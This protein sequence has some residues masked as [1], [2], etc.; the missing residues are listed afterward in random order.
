MR[1]GIVLSLIS[2]RMSAPLLLSSHCRA[3]EFSHVCPSHVF[4]VNFFIIV[5]WSRK[6]ELYLYPFVCLQGIMLH[7]TIFR[8]GRVYQYTVCWRKLRVYPPYSKRSRMCGKYHCIPST[9]A[10]EGRYLETHICRIQ[11]RS[12]DCCFCDNGCGLANVVFTCMVKYILKG[13]LY[14][15]FRWADWLYCGTCWER[16]SPY[17]WS[18]N[19]GQPQC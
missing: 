19:I 8:N 11:K 15:R 1:V 13:S 16:H 9:R 5:P 2:V 18:T 10:L 3:S 12:E 7:H 14:F 17:Q 4:F 6:V